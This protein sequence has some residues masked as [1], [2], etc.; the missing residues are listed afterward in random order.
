MGATL[1]LLEQGEPLEKIMLRGGWQKDS[2]SM[3]YVRNF[4]LVLVNDISCIMS[5]TYIKGISFL[6]LFVCLLVSFF[7]CQLAKVSVCLSAYF[8]L[9]LVNG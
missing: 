6:F 8:Y 5:S 2:T 4:L 9:L 3:K 7:V 1:D